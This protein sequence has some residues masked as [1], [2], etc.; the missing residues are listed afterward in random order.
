MNVLKPHLY[1]YPGRLLEYQFGYGVVYHPEQLRWLLGAVVQQSE[2]LQLKQETR[3][4]FLAA[5]FGF[6]SPAGLLM[7]LW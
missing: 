2:H 7:F 5:A 1:N 3:V 6:S 4:Q